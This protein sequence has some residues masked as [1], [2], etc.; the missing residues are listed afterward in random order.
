MFSYD[1]GIDLGTANTLVYVKDQGIVLREPSVVAMKGDKVKA[2]G[3]EAKRML[4]RTPGSVVAIRPLKEGVIADFEVAQEMLSYFIR[5]A[6]NRRSLRGPRILIAHPSGITEVERRAI[7]DSAAEAGARAVQLIEEPMAAA[8]GVGLP[9]SEPI[10]SM[11]VDIGGGTTEVAIISLSGIVYSQSENC[12]GDALDDTICRHMLAAHNLLI[13]PRTAEDIKI[14]VGSAHPLQQEL[15]MEVKG[16]DRGTGLPKTVTVRS[17]EI[18]E[19]LQDKLDII[20]NAI[21]QT[22]DHCPPELASDLYDRG[23][24]VAGGGALLRGLSDL[25][26]EQTGLPITIA[27]DPLSAVAEGTGKFIQENSRVFEDEN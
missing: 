24:T 9:V 26:H 3:E 18:R 17:E 14:S 12:G 13:G 10:G 19:A 21:R 16:R 11:I 20:V 27:D 7:I 22:L 6:C 23:I 2:V 1:I 5:K 25:L 15:Q 8:I 4:G